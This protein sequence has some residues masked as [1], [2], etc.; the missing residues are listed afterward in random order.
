MGILSSLVALFV[1][2]DFSCFRT[3]AV[4][5]GLNLKLGVDTGLVF[6]DKAAAGL[7]VTWPILVPIV[8]K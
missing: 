5:M 7:A 8:A 2:N 6:E 4:S 3:V 1:F